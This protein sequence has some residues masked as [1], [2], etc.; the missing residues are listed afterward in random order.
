MKKLQYK[1]EF[2]VKENVKW[3]VATL[4]FATYMSM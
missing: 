1:K 2:T 3:R 4:Y